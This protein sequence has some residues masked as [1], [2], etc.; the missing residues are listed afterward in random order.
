MGL[1]T[2]K[3]LKGL[4]FPDGKHV[5]I[6]GRKLCVKNAVRLWHILVLNHVIE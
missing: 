5:E 1:K 6:E 4:P 2:K 3:K